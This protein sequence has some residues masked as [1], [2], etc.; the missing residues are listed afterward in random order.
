MVVNARLEAGCIEQGMEHFEGSSVLHFISFRYAAFDS[1]GSFNTV[2]KDTA[3]PFPFLK[4]FREGCKKPGS[5]LEL[6]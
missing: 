5:L 1:G 4:N 6:L 3:R 2:K